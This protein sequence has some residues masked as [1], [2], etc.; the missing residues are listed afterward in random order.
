[1]M[2]PG[3]WTNQ[4]PQDGNEDLVALTEVKERY[5]YSFEKYQEHHGIEDRGYRHKGRFAKS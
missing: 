4:W 1:M 3:F 2:M 5:A